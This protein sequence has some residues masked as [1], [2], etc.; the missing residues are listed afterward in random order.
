[1][2]LSIQQTNSLEVFY[3][4]AWF[5][6]ILLGLAAILYFYQ[7][8]AESLWI[9]E[10]YSVFDA[11]NKSVVNLLIHSSRPVYLI[12]LKI[13]MR[14]GSGETWLRSLNIPFGLGSVFL[15]YQ[16]GRRTAG[17]STGLIAA[18]LLT[19]SVLFINHVQ[20]VRMYASSIFWGL[21]SSLA[22]I[23]ALEKPATS[24]ICLWAM[25]R[26]LAIGTTPINLLLLPADVLILGL[27]F[28]KPLRPLVPFIVGFLAVIFLGSLLSLPFFAAFPKFMSQWVAFNPKPDGE[29]ILALLTRE[30]TVGQDLPFGAYHGFYK[31]HGFLLAGLFG[32]SLFCL[33]RQPQLGKILTWGIFPALIVLVISSVSSSLWIPRFLLFVA[34]YLFI[35]MAAG[36]IRIAHHSKKMAAIIVLIH[37]IAVGGG[38]WNYYVYPQRQDWRGV[39][40]T[41]QSYQKP[42]DILLMYIAHGGPGRILEYYYKNAGPAYFFPHAKNLA[43]IK[44][45]QSQEKLSEIMGT[46]IKTRVWIV[47]QSHGKVMSREIFLKKLE[48]EFHIQKHQQFFGRIELFLVIPQNR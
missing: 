30:F 1:M 18:F 23:R 3:K 35:L 31:I 9:D 44:R 34:P 6:V 37:G 43:F 19:F 24:W 11:Q 21:A 2:K 28:R 38:L 46:P 10:I 40:Q 32:I 33:R 42:D 20:E 29:K 41:L 22:L 12:L 36:F 14:F 16:L 15:I 27:E 5:L 17:K 25:G 4:P 39:F 8:G 45:M 13:W 26:L 47:Y 7:L 48:S